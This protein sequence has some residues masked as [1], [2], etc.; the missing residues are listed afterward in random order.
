MIEIAAITGLG[1]HRMPA[2]MRNTI[3]LEAAGRASRRSWFGLPAFVLA[4]RP[5][6]VASM[7]A[8]VLALVALPM[9]FRNGVSPLRQEGP[10]RIEVVARGGSV[11]L[12]WQDG[13]R[14][15]YTVYKSTDPRTLGSAEAHV[16][17]GNAWTDTRPESSP[18]VFY[19]IEPGNGS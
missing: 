14:D 7:A 3:A 12:A 19:R 13:E 4:Q 16:V 1:E 15:T 6:L 2:S 9:A 8:L 17:T 10:M 18:V 5:G 11:H